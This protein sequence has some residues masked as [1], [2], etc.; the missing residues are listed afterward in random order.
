MK[1]T[2]AIVGLFL[3]ITLIM[4]YPLVLRLGSSVRDLGDPL[5]NSWI[6][7]WNIERLIH[8]DASGVFDANI[9]YPQKK[10]LAYSEF[11]VPQSLVALPVKLLS[12]NPVLAHNF[13]VL[14]AFLTTGLGMFFLAR[15]LT[16]NT[17]AGIAAGFIFA[18]SPFMFAHLYQVQVLTAGGIPL[19]FLFLHK[20]FA[21]DRLKDIML[22]GLFFILQALANGYYALYLIIFA[23]LFVLVFALVRKKFKDVRFW[24]RTALCG[25]MILACLG[26][27]FYQYL[28]VQKEMGF[29]REIG[30]TAA[31]SSY[32][33]TPSINNLYGKATA[34]FARVEGQLF[35]GLA[36][37]ILACIGAVYF[38]RL[39]GREGPSAQPQRAAGPPRGATLAVWL[40]TLAAWASTGILYVVLTRGGFDLRLGN[41]VILRAHSPI[42]TG[43]VVL[44]LVALRMG[45]RRLWRVR[46]LLA[47]VPDWESPW[48]YVLILVLAFLFTFGAQGPYLLLYKYF[49]GFS[50]LRV[51]ARFHVFVMF[52]V[53]VLAAYG[54]AGLSRRLTH[55]KAKNVLLAAL[56]LIIL[57]E[58]LSLPIPLARVPV[59]DEIPEVYKW[60]A[61]EK[62]DF[63][64]IE[65]PLPYGD[66]L[67]FK[68][69]T[70][71]VYYST[72]HWK[73]LV[74]GY[75]GFF[76]KLYEEL[77]FRY[78]TRPAAPLVRDLKALGVK[79]VIVHTSEMGRK[80]ARRTLEDLDLLR[81]DVREV[82]RF[83]QDRV[84]ELLYHPEEPRDQIVQSRPQFMPRGQWKAIASVSGDNAGK[85]IDGSLETRWDTAGRQ[86]TGQWFELDLGSVVS[87][88][89]V[90]LKLGSSFKDYPRGVRFEVSNDG[91]E[92]KV[93]AQT[94]KVDVSIRAFIHPKEIALDFPFPPV[95][96]RFLRIVQ[97][98]EDPFYF[99]SIHELSVWAQ[100]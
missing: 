13:V 45:L 90:S 43:L 88:R 66:N 64:V 68:L 14:F 31:L 27:F 77:L 67:L 29:K 35:P 48:I 50:G 23:G 65:L 24:L 36:A 76:P 32:A 79:V 1:R 59:K 10:T 28:Q 81:D 69:E 95:T 62:G 38:L 12:G 60:L 93:A 78:A 3:V 34:R 41:A 54:V 8:L 61:R 89:G 17:L 91:R 74:N 22:F 20:F 7:S 15:Y 53:A 99:W 86:K 42:R 49:P 30:F 98:G 39:K 52:G 55:L 72:Y 51:A 33:A 4:T 44:A 21:D 63:P 6:L 5:L 84:Y 82:A 18:F 16:R 40:A 75:S 83:G 19:A 70:P 85:A 96:A 92:W 9:F 58:Y 57:V 11:L 25:A 26:P 80:K 73:K 37:F 47:L 97:T 2:S 71:R 100:D 94:D 87:F 56:T 46:P